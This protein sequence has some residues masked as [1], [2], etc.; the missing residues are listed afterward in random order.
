MIIE[1]SDGDSHLL[2]ISHFNRTKTELFSLVGVISMLFFPTLVP[3]YL[4]YHYKK[5]FQ[6]F[7]TN[8]A[9]PPFFFSFNFSLGNRTVG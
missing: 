8:V 1:K 9:A 5:G 3:V 4:S 6:C 7:V 2:H